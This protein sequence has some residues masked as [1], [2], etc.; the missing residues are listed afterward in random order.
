MTHDLAEADRRGDRQITLSEGRTG[1]VVERRD[2]PGGAELAAR[3]A[4][5]PPDRMYEAL[6]LAGA[7]PS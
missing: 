4:A 2:G 6:C 7:S 1:P 5:V 3:L